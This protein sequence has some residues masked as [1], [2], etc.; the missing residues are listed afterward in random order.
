MNFSK[1][2]FYL[3]IAILIIAI[4]GGAIYYLFNA[5]IFADT[6]SSGTSVA[7]NQ[8]NAQRKEDVQ[9]IAFALNI[10]QRFT[11]S[12]PAT[13]GW[14]A[15]M[16]LGNNSNESLAEAK[17]QDL[18][19]GGFPCDPLLVDSNGK[20][21]RATENA[22]GS[23]NIG[24]MYYR[25]DYCGG[26]PKTYSVYAKLENASNLNDKESQ[27][28]QDTSIKCNAANKDPVKNGMNYR[29]GSEKS[30]PSTENAI[31]DFVEQFEPAGTPISNNT[32][33]TVTLKMEWICR[34]GRYSRLLLS[35]MANPINKLFSKSGFCYFNAVWEG[36]DNQDDISKLQYR[37]KLDN[38]DWSPWGS[39]RLLLRQGGR[40][41]GTLHIFSVQ[42]KDSTGL[43]G[44]A[45]K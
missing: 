18:I 10:Y 9:K 44:E 41:F 25:D 35:F 24:Y 20:C 27:G 11:K 32:P 38:K 1:K 17:F 34:N 33:P 7:A 19:Y 40:N 16:D 42:V 6:V 4:V 2:Y 12:Y 15:N 23:S 13:D 26:G 45:T 8:R 30:T 22:N 5:R 29:I 36:Q 21:Q 31:K 39:T 28:M 37:Y 14:I 43:I 3:L